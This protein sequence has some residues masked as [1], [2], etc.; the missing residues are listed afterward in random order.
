MFKGRKPVSKETILNTISEEDLFRRYCTNFVEVDTPF[1]SELREDSNPSCRITDLGSGLRY[2]DFGSANPATDIWGYV[3]LKYNLSFIDVIERVA[4]DCDV[5]NDSYSHSMN[6]SMPIVDSIQHKIKP[7]TVILIKRRDWLLVDKQYWADKYEIGKALLEFYGVVPIVF[8]WVGKEN[9]RNPQMLTADLLSYCYNY[10]W[11]NGILLRKI[12][13]PYSKTA[14][15][16]SNVDNTIVQGIDNIPKTADI[17]I[18]S[19]SLKDVMCWRLLGYA[20]IAPNSESTWIPQIV[21][22]KLLNRYKHIVIFFDNDISGLASITKYS[23]AYHTLHTHIPLEYREKNVS[24]F[25]EKYGMV[26][27][28]QLIEYLFNAISILSTNH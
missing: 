26:Q 28:N 6:Q 2:K 15:W 11:H 23:E 19:S 8:Y 27:T 16:I 25:I 13:Q 4:N 5:Q 1:C 12:Y 24:D 18:I 7:K 17:L 21:W 3:Q 20:A 14:K 9:N 22:E 10:Y